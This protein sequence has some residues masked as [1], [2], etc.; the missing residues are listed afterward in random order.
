MNNDLVSVKATDI[1]DLVDQLRDKG[2]DAS[3]AVVMFCSP[4]AFS[5]EDPI[6]NLQYSVEG[7]VLGLDWVLLGA[8]NIEDKER[9][10][11]FITRA[12]HAVTEQEMNNVR[13]L[14]VEGGDVADLGFRIVTEYYQIK[15]TAE[16]DLLVDGFEYVQRPNGLQPTQEAAT[17]N[18]QGKPAPVTAQEFLKNVKPWEERLAELRAEFPGPT[19]EQLE[20]LVP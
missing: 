8:R 1:P 5:G 14:R 16:I 20:G 2:G 6:I 12:G 15:P 9:I 13:F 10:A 4:Y 7:S 3:Y 19:D 11:A 18:Q 17:H